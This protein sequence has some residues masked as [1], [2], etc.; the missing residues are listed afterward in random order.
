MAAENVIGGN[1]LSEVRNKVLHTRSSVGLIYIV[2][3]IIE[4]LKRI[5]GNENGY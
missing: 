5:G 2:M 3:E 4:E 1:A